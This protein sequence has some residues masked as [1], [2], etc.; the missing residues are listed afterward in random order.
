MIPSKERVN[1]LRLNARKRHG[2]ENV[3]K[4]GNFVPGVDRNRA[5]IRGFILFRV[6]YSPAKYPRDIS[7]RASRN[8]R[9]H[10]HSLSPVTGS[11]IRW[12]LSCETHEFFFLLFHPSPSISLPLSRLFHVPPR[13]YISYGLFA[14]LTNSRAFKFQML[15]G[16]PCIRKF[17]RRIGSPLKEAA[18]RSKNIPAI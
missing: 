5:S 17:P 3:C 15:S 7:Y 16:I 18:A 6:V 8:N 4:Q 10:T 14:Y 11:R 2:C 1:K 12:N 9:M 13:R